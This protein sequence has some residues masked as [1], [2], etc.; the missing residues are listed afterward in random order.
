M[1][2][3]RLSDCNSQQELSPTTQV[4]Q[5]WS[6]VFPKTFQKLAR[7]TKSM[8]KP[9]KSK[10]CGWRGILWRMTLCTQVVVN[11]FQTL[12]NELYTVNVQNIS[13]Q[14]AS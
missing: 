12:Q 1:H 6:L 11:M 2:A 13:V 7:L 5:Q 14:L 8:T 4:V 9:S 10:P 3:S